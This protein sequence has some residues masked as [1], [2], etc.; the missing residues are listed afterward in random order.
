MQLK[1]VL[2]LLTLAVGLYSATALSQSQNAFDNANDNAS[3]LRCATKHPTPAEAKKLEK[4]LRQRLAALNAKGKPDK[5]GGGGGNG[6][7]GNG[8]GGDG[9]GGGGELP[10]PSCTAGKTCV[11]VVFHVI[12]DGRG[13]GAVSD[14]TIAAQMDVIN[15]A[16]SG[17]DS[18]GMAYEFDLLKTTRTADRKWYTGCY[19]RSERS[20]KSS[21][22]EGGASTLNIYSCNPSNGILG[23][24]TFPTS[25]DAQPSLDGVVILDESMPGGTASPYNQGDTLTHEIGHWLGLYH[26]FQGGCGDY[27]GGSSDFVADTAPEAEPAYQCAPR[28]SCTAD[29]SFD[30]IFNFMDYTPDSCMY[31][32]T[33][34]QTTRSDQFWQAYRAL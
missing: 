19:G 26:T 34:G 31:E 17:V 15:Q 7:G 8:G 1:P 23:Y 13:N 20:M 28:D 21:L 4:E 18:G 11:G 6:G 9:G 12:T 25:Y 24:A 32:F 30:P 2:P 33:P 22:R 5:P 14:A 10:T 27:S 3:F 29:A 16:F